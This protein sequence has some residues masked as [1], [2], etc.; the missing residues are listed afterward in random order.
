MVNKN[1][2]IEIDLFEVLEITRFYTLC[3]FF[4]MVEDIDAR[5]DFYDRYK[6]HYNLVVGNGAFESYYIKSTPFYMFQITRSFSDY[7]DALK[8]ILIKRSLENSSFHPRFLVFMRGFVNQLNQFEDAYIDLIGEDSIVSE[9]RS[10]SLLMFQYRIIRAKEFVKNI[11]IYFPESKNELVY[12][13]TDSLDI[14]QVNKLSDIGLTISEE[15]HNK[16]EIRLKGPERLKVLLT[17]CPDL[18]SKLSRLKSREKGALIGYIIGYNPEDSRK[19][20]NDIDSLN[21]EFSLEKEISSY[22]EQFSKQGFI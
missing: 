8:T 10:I 2:G 3:P 13:K 14:N 16:K 7:L 22:I 6:K 9:S 4:Y 1:V 5:P 15:I 12:F 19:A 11:C 20:F 18:V 17:V 21:L